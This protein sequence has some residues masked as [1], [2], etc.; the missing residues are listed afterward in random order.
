M[1][2]TKS[3]KQV[4]NQ[5]F[6]YLAIMAA[7][8]L[9]VVGGLALWAHNFTSTMVRTEL[10]A[11]KVYFPEKGSSAFDEATYPDIQQYAGQLVDTPA[12]AKAYAN[13]YIGRHLDKV[14]SGKVYSEVSAESMKDPSDAKLQAQKA[15]LF[16]GETLRAMLLTSGYGF[17]TVGE[18]AGI[19]AYVAFVSATVLAGVGTILYLKQR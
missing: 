19:A 18:I 10:S 12:K 6:A 9:V 14:A 11:Q 1:K 15:T 16:Q 2:K 7:V 17:G 4:T 3:Q 8:L 5:V 13:G